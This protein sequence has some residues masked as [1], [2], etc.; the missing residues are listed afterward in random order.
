M[1]ALTDM[2]VKRCMDTH[3]SRGFVPVRVPTPY[4]EYGL[5]LP[6]DHQPGLYGEIAPDPPCPKWLH[7]ATDGRWFIPPMWVEGELVP[8]TGAWQDEMPAEGG[9][10]WVT[11]EVQAE[12][13]TYAQGSISGDPSYIPYRSGAFEMLSV[14]LI[15]QAPGVP[16][17]A[18]IKNFD[19]GYSKL[20]RQA[21]VVGQRPTDHRPLAQGKFFFLEEGLASLTW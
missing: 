13:R 17:P 8:G 9:T 18:E 5:A 16:A 6:D 1:N 20:C 14:G 10:V 19:T 21:Y 3:G 4:F 7:Q 12:I 15:I 11:C 2:Q